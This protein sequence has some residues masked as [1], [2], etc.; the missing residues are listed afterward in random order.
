MS[1]ALVSQFA[2]PVLVF[3]GVTASALLART[4]ALRGLLQWAQR[5][6]ST[7]DDALVGAIRTPSIYWCM[8]IGLYLAIG[9]SNLAAQYIAYA[10]KVLHILVI[11][12]VTLVV[13]NLSTQFMTYAIRKAE[14]PLPVTGLSRAVVNGI[15]LTIGI[16]I[17]L[18]T[19]GVSI[20]PLL[21]A[22]GVGGLAVALAL[23]DTLGNLFA[24]MHILVEKTIR[25]GDFVKLES[26]EE[27]Y[28]ADIGWR[29][30]RLR[31]LPNNLVVI[32]NSKLAQSIVTNYDLPEK[33]MALLIPIS[34]SYDNDPGRVE[35][36]LVEEAVK[37]SQD[38]PGLLSEPAPFVRFIPGFRRFFA[39]LYP[40]LPGE[41]V[42]GSIPGPAR[43][44]KADLQPV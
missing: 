41:G 38:I 36:M 14:I 8:A 34:V 11:L 29:T 30:T 27:G 6:R 9:T 15:I 42:C 18:G 24:G 21:T 22:L 1:Y 39:Q 17:V 19:L 16:L 33:R 12:S 7:I 40:H 2:L 10:F 35:R 5:T 25:V 43:I 23:Q 26:G 31:L 44:A 20:T 4:L 28:V 13:A 3:A 37:G 32:P